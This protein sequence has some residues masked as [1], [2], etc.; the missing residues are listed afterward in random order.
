MLTTLS[1]F[2]SQNSLPTNHSFNLFNGFDTEF[3][4]V[5]YVNLQK[6]KLNLNFFYLK[7][8]FKIDI[9]KNYLLF[10]KSCNHKT[11]LHYD[12]SICIPKNILYTNSNVSQ[13]GNITIITVKCD[14]CP[15][16]F[17]K[18]IVLNLKVDRFQ[19]PQK[20]LWELTILYL[21]LFIYLL[22]YYLIII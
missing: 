19:V 15:S 10:L 11:T 5:L 8:E 3:C 17:H 21:K 9:F 13:R 4:N 12:K 2:N 7:F 1:C 6:L 18:L 22:D 16:R 20:S 14:I